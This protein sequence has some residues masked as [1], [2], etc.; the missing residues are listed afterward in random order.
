MNSWYWNNSCL[1]KK[2][3]KFFASTVKLSKLTYARIPQWQHYAP[4][5][6]LLIWSVAIHMPLLCSFLHG[7]Q[8]VCVCPVWILPTGRHSVMLP[9]AQRFHSRDSGPICWLLQSSRGDELCRK[10]L[11]AGSV[12]CRVFFI[13]SGWVGSLSLSFSL[14]PP[15]N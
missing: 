3:K 1:K 5:H 14:L 4:S 2:K 9:F 12:S 10:R 6:A 13:I 11:A 7:P 15:A 8:S